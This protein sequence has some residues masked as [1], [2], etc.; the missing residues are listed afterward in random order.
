MGMSM[1]KWNEY[2]TAACKSSGMS[3]SLL[4]STVEEATLSWFEELGY[5]V[6][7]SPHITPG[8]AAAAW[9]SFGDAVLVGRILD[10]LL[11]KTLS[12]EI[13]VPDAEK[14]IASVL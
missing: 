10:T 12:S 9:D 13:R 5:A 4:E 11:P 2:N 7:H 8:E 1:E 3:G 14:I 6:H